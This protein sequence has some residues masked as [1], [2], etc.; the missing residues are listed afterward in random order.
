MVPGLGDLP[1]DTV[2][3]AL[4]LLGVEAS[5]V[6]V[7]RTVGVK[8]LKE[9][10]SP[11]G[12]VQDLL[13]DAPPA[14]QQ[15]FRRLATEG[16]TTVEDLIGRGWAGRGLLPEPLDWLQRRALIAVGPEGL[17]HAVAEARTSYGALT[18]DLDID[19]P[20]AGGVAAG[21]ADD[22]PPA[23]S[24]A[25]P[26]EVHPAGAV[27][28]ASTPQALTMA[29]GVGPAEL[30]AVAETVAVSSKSA[31]VVRAALESAG[32]RLDDAHPV[33]ADPVTPA[34]PGAE[35]QAVGPRAI[36]A[37]IERALEERRQLRLEY[38]AS[39]RGGQAS[40]R[41][42]DPWSFAED[43]LVGWCHLRKGER[44]FAVDRMGSARLLASELEHLPE[45][46]AAEGGP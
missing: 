44:T 29:L 13:T 25:P 43:L 27:V 19:E 9:R 38:Y 37:L 2:L 6:A 17:V 42:V 3:E 16:A 26:L 21:A 23:P 10:L 30:R 18:L 32:L 8:E 46:A 22:H 28:V 11:P 40:T 39:S 7:P 24:H 14:A 20:H 31:T 34:L 41:V 15:A 5:A 45:E 12:A 4:R 33:H 36:R 1:A 35:E